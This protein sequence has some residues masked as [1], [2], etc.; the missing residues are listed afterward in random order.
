[1]KV[2]LK[3]LIYTIWA[4]AA[5]IVSQLAIGYLMVF[6]VGAETFRQ[7]L[8]TAIYSALSYIFAI[9]L[10]IIIPK[11]LN[12][13]QTHHKSTSKEKHKTTDSKTYLEKLGI[14]GWLTWADIGLAPLGMIAY[15]LLSAALMALFSAFPWFNAEEVQDVGFSTYVSGLDRMIAFFV[16]VVVAPIAEEVIFRGFLYGKLKD[17]LTNNYSKALTI[18]ISNLLVSLIFGIVHLQWN[19]GVNVFAMSVIL[20]G[21]REFT[22]T[23][24][25]GIILHMLKNGIAF[26]LLYVLGV[27]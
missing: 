22:G 26:Y 17:T 21:L 7:P 15:L 10:L 9:V 19:V 23:I 27:R 5:V 2:L 20:C 18:I 8:P 13:R 16:I 24:Y 12:D 25:S 14:K 1:M 6:I 4:G 3:A 11:L